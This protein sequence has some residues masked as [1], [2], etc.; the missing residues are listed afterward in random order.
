VEVKERLE[1]SWE[2]IWEVWNWMGME[3]GQGEK[4]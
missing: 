1:R 4:K 3:V 2:V